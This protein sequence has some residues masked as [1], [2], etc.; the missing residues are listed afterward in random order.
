MKK[1]EKLVTAV[2][3]ETIERGTFRLEPVEVPADIRE[4]DGL[5]EDE[6]YGMLMFDSS[7][8]DTFAIWG[9]AA[10]YMQWAWSLPSIEAVRATLKP[11]E[12]ATVMMLVALGI[13]RI[14]FPDDFAPEPSRAEKLMGI[15]ADHLSARRQRVATVFARSDRLKMRNQEWLW[16]GRIPKRLLTLLAGMQGLGKSTLTAWFAAQVSTGKIGAEPAGVMILSAEDD[17]ETTIVPRLVAA[18]ADLERVII[19]RIDKHL[20]IPQDLKVIEEAVLLYDV[21]VIIIDPVLSYLD[22]DADAFNP[23]AVRELLTPLHELCQRRDVTVLGLMHFR[24][25]ANAAVLHRITSSSAFTET[26]RSV[27]M[28]GKP[29]DSEQLAL[30]HPKCNVGPEMPTLAVSIEGTVVTSETGLTVK[31]SFVKIGDDLP[32]VTAE[33]FLRPTQGGRKPRERDKAVEFLRKLQAESADGR[34]NAS[35]AKKL[36]R[37]DDGSDETLKRARQHMGLVSQSID[38]VWW[39]RDAD[40]M[41]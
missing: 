7:D 33:D 11:E 14:V 12:V 2:I 13:G 22:K 37:E 3:A 31:T 38:G 27:L 15:Y 21:T 8:G 32:G 30:A 19:H 17:P 26:A 16:D 23:K 6:T 1:W 28:L 40:D 35:V 41:A 36:W 4:R 39:W 18:G 10:A 29:Q 9:D 34:I 5:P 25:D 24:K 20:T